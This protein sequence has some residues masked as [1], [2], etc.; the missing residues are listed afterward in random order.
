MKQKG[1]QNNTTYIERIEASN[2][3]YAVTHRV[4]KRADLA[5]FLIE[6]PGSTSIDELITLV[7]EIYNGYLKIG[8][9]CAEID[10][11]AKHGVNLPPN[12][13]GLTEDQVVDLKLK[14]EWGD[15]CIPSG[16]YIEYKDEIGRRNGRAL[17]EKMVEVLK[18]TVDEAKQLIGRDTVNR[19]RCMNKATVNEVPI[20]LRGA[21]T[22]VYPVEL[23]PYDP[24]KKE[25]DNEE[26]L[27]EATLWISGKEMLREKLISDYV[28]R[29]E[30]TKIVAELSKRG[31]DAPAREPVTDEK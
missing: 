23:P 10:E 11:L 13:Q 20:M 15:K 19:D 26:D 1:G 28:G 21:L 18:R 29:N 27:S 25:L 7:C 22:V 8:R 24:I 14:D 3:L 16:G 12:L 31:A 30:K 6:V 9:I 5:Q 2:L 17:C 4:I